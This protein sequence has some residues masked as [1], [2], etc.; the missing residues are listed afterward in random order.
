METLK[1]AY[2]KLKQLIVGDTLHSIVK[3]H[4]I[5]GATINIETL[6]DKY[7]DKKCLSAQGSSYNYYSEQ[8]EPTKTIKETESELKAKSGLNPTLINQ[9]NSEPDF[10]WSKI[11]QGTRCPRCGDFNIQYR[12]NDLKGHLGRL[13]ILYRC[14]RCFNELRELAKNKR[15][16]RVKPGD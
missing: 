9:E 11:P 14:K 13:N 2:I 4:D 3:M 10:L 6:Y 1:E 8:A 16:K 7:F 15:W 5:D 12:I